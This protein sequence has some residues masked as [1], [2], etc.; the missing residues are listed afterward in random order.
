[1][2]EAGGLE[3]RGVAAEDREDAVCVHSGE[4][5]SLWPSCEPT[6]LK[7]DVGHPALCGSDVRGV[8]RTGSL[9]RLGGSLG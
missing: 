7:R 2:G 8:I 5:F 6:S 3:L 1:M 9:R 4:K